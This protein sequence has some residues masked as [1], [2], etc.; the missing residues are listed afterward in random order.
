[1]TPRR[2]SRARTLQPSAAMQH[3][4]SSSSSNSFSRAERSTR[5]NNKISPHRRPSTQRSESTDDLEAYPRSDLPQTHHRHRGRNNDEQDDI[6]QALGDEYD[7]ED[8]DE[9]EIT[10]CLCGQQDYP[11]L[12]LIY[13]GAGSASVTKQGVKDD[14]V[15]GASVSA[16]DMQ[17]DEPGSLFIQCDSCKVWQHG[18]CV[19]IMEEASSP[20]EY[21]C[22]EC[23]K[24]LHKIITASNGQKSSRYL[25]VV[26]SSSTSSSRSSSLG[27]SRNL[28][29]KKNRGSSGLLSTKRRSTMNSRDAAYDEEQLRRAIE[30]SK[31]DS[32]SVA[33][34][35][36]SRRG[37]RS[38]SDSEA[39][40]HAAK[41]QRTGSPSSSLSKRSN[42]AS[43]PPSDDENKSNSNVSQEGNGNKK[44]RGVVRN[45]REREA[46]TTEKEPEKEINDVVSRRKNRS[47]RRKDDEEP[48]ET[49]SPTKTSSIPPT[50]SQSTPD[51]PS[52]VNEP[53]NTKSST[54]KTGRPPARRGRLGRN[55]YTRDRDSVNGDISGGGIHSPRRGQ[56][57]DTGTGE[58]P[59]GVH[60]GVNGVYLNGGESGKPSKPRYMNPQRTT[61]NE[62]K[63]RVAAI[64]EFISQLQLDLASSPE[65]ISGT[66]GAPVSGG[67]EEAGTHITNG[68]H[69]SDESTNYVA[70]KIEANGI[71]QPK[72][73]E[74]KDL[75]SLEMMD[76]LTRNLVKWQQK[77]G[78]YGEK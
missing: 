72:E 19:G 74:F 9:E 37:K 5:S 8:G 33:D 12:P 34:D 50:I 24:D 25:P 40:K 60:L 77:F 62:M 13:Q 49:I 21:F 16:E 44:T 61:M 76:A 63:R 71:T 1:M 47:E 65:Q 69:H 66:G 26:G 43:H 75:T 32:K 18:G 38:R 67:K 54:R 46:Q 3:T 7:E 31:E 36:G 48:T 6:L 78:K 52:L 56:S 15:Q 2:S 39:N 57:G 10:R 27:S 22:E 64:L 53:S 41:R 35:L 68:D 51:A 11:G 23:R 20:D 70:E 28:K 58:S 30:E 73:K 45:Q 29:N 17:S 42:S 4:S 14:S 55:Q 59:T